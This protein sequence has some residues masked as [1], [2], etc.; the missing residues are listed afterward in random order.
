VKITSPKFF[1]LILKNQTLGGNQFLPDRV[2]K[3]TMNVNS[4]ITLHKEE[5]NGTL[6]V[7]AVDLQFGYD[8][9]SGKGDLARDIFSP[10]AP[11]N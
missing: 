11:E 6:K 9:S 5:L 2:L 7:E 10:E 4:N 1:T 8:E 3:G